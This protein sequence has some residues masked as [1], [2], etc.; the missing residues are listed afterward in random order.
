M[1]DGTECDAWVVGTEFE[2]IRHAIWMA[3]G[4][5]K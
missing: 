2:D 1:K 3:E 5:G 4:N